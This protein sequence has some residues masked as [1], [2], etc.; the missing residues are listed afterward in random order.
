MSLPK[1][2]LRMFVN[3]VRRKM[4]VLFLP[5]M[6]EVLDASREQTQKPK[7]GKSSTTIRPGQRVTTAKDAT[8]ELVQQ[9]LI[10]VAT[11]SQIKISNYVWFAMKVTWH[12]AD[13]TLRMEINTAASQDVKIQMVPVNP[14]RLSMRK[15]VT[16]SSNNSCGFFYHFAPNKERI[17]YSMLKN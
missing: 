7:Q 5:A 13:L 3:Q 11:Q 17:L 9:D 15:S 2:P 6:H 10:F 12:H 16:S 1:E 8:A 4:R 14:G